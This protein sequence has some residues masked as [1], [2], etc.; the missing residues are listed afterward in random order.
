M[1]KILLFIVIVFTVQFANAQGKLQ[2]IDHNGQYITNGQK[3]F[4]FV[5][6]IT[7]TTVSNEYFIKNNSSEDINIKCVRNVISAV[8]GS[9]NT[10]CA[11]G[12]CYPPDANESNEYLLTANT[13]IPDDYPFSADYYANGNPGTTEIVYK[14]YNVDNQTDTISFSVTF[15]DTDVIENSLQLFDAEGNEMTYGFDQEVSVEDLDLETVSPEYFIRNN[16]DKDLNLMCKR[17]VLENIEGSEN[18]FCT[19]GTCLPPSGDLA[20]PAIITANTTSGADDPFSTHYTANGFSG[21]TKIHYRFFDQNNEF[22]E[23]SFTIT[24]DG[25]TG[26]NSVLTSQADLSATPNPATNYINLNIQGLDMAHANLMIY[27]AVGELVM[28][29]PSIDESS[30]TIDVSALNAG[31]YLYRL[32]GDQKMSKTSKLLIQ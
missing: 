3:L 17:T 9:M 20:G 18:Y 24:F 28:V 4:V 26:I 22:D 10:F 29:V 27:N 23:F 19:L 5:E 15:S 21:K 7:G 2:L 30:Q 25:T 14:F 11:L 13:I 1:K 8:E 31:I 16:S 12:S 32:E 6:D